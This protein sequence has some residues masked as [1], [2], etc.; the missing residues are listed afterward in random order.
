MVPFVATEVKGMTSE[1]DKSDLHSHHEELV[2]GLYNQ[3]K[4]IFESSEQPMYLYL[5]DT[6]KTCNQKL[7]SLLG[8]K[9]PNEWASVEGF[10]DLVE[11]KSME[12][13]AAAYNDAMTRMV[14]STVNVKWL[15]KSGDKVDTSVILVPIAYNEHLFAL[16]FVS[17]KA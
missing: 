12:S 9:T 10:S 6:H 2:G 11:E 7:A 15:K 5:D 17:P 3:M 16:H 4:S 8:Y 1:N 14:G 13:L